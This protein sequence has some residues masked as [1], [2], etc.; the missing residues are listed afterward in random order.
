MFTFLSH[1][2]NANQNDP[3]ILHYTSQNG[4]H[5]S[6]KQQHM[7]KRI[8]RK[9]NTSP[10]LVGLQAHPTTLKSIWWFLRKLEIDLPEDPAIQFLGHVPKRSS[11]ISQGQVLIKALFVIARSWK[12]PRC[13]SK[14]GYRK[15]G[16]LT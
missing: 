11:T 16:S 9:G 13:P 2:G 8:W 14:N 7:L 1:Q 12:Q 4:Q 15:C 6:L 5:Q 3:E 10:L